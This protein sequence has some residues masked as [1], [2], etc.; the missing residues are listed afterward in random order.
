MRAQK[1]R[2]FWG[3]FAAVSATFIQALLLVEAIPD[4]WKVLR[5]IFQAVVMALGALGYRSA[6]LTL[7]PSVAS[8]ELDMTKMVKRK[9]DDA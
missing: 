8:A 5:K 3:A 6:L 4:E 7:P 1:R 9:K 2:A